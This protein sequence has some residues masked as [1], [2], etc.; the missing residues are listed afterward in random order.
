MALHSGLK[1]T[2]VKGGSQL[3]GGIYIFLLGVHGRPKLTTIA[4][5]W[6]V[7]HVAVF[8]VCTLAGTLAHSTLFVVI[9]HNSHLACLSAGDESEQGAAEERAMRE[10]ALPV[11]DSPAP[12][13]GGC[14]ML[15]VGAMHAHEPCSHAWCLPVVCR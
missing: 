12:W 4:Q 15:H 13:D 2:R 11:I 7:L 6:V 3:V 1:K 14:C 10:R 8:P 9:L 5:L